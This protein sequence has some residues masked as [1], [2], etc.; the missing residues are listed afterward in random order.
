MRVLGIDPGIATCGYGVIEAA[1][2]EWRLVVAGAIRPTQRGA[3]RLQ[4]LYKAMRAILAAHRPN[5]AAVE[6]LYHN[7]N[8]KTAADVGQA[9]GVA[10]LALVQAGIDIAE[11]T[12]TQMKL[13]ITGNGAA[14]K[15]QVQRLVA[16]RLRLAYPP[17]PDDAA[18]ALGL[19]LCYVQAIGLR[20]RVAQAMGAGTL[21]R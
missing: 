9:R 21:A 7:R 8:V 2:G 11:Y 1:D 10:M 3:A 18:D 13:A 17:Q 12:P 14:D 20:Q 6:L 15:G 4:E 5:A 16:M 19:C